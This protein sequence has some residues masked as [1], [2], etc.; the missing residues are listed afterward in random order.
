MLAA[1]VRLA[2]KTTAKPPRTTSSSKLRHFYNLLNATEMTFRTGAVL[3]STAIAAVESTAAPAFVPR[4][5][6]PISQNIKRAYYLGHHRSTLRQLSALRSSTDFYVDVRDYRIPLTSAN[7]LLERALAGL[8]RIIVYTKRDL[9]V[10]ATK[11]DGNEVIAGNHDPRKTEA[12]LREMHSSNNTAESFFISATSP[13]AKTAAALHAAIHTMTVNSA[14]HRDLSVRPASGL[15]VGMPNVG[16]STLLNALRATAARKPSDNPAKKNKQLGK[17]AKTGDTPGITRSV[18]ERTHITAFT[19]KSDE[20]DDGEDVG[21]ARIYARDTPGVFLPYITSPHEMVKLALT[22][23][24]SSSVVPLVVVADYLLFWMNL[25]SPS[26]YTSAGSNSSSSSGSSKTK[27]M[28]LCPTPTNDIH[29]FLQHTATRLGKVKR[30]AVPDEEGAAE[31]LIRRYREGLLGR[32]ILD[33]VHDPETLK[34]FAGREEK[35]GVWWSESD[36]NFQR[37]KSTS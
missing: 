36:V 12:M 5:E 22:G 21:L 29:F 7:P 33:D 1:K 11:G 2:P 31:W 15:L 35:A 14:P 27:K 10:P 34:A 8:P 9:G 25:I 18:S 26:I 13:S 3:K 17:V 23:C 24:V 32:F 28:V 20:T 30:H 16:K 19:P 37:R 6:F 4:T